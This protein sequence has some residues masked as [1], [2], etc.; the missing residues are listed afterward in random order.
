MYGPGKSG[1]VSR[2]TKAPYLLYYR[3]IVKAGA[4][5]VIGSFIAK[6][7]L[8]EPFSE[9]LSELVKFYEQSGDKSSLYIIKVKWKKKGR[10]I[11]AY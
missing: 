1:M 9:R 7:K 8:L 11:I 4:E 5:T 2:G 10:L 6:E 3:D